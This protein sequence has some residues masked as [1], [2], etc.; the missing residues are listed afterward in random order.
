MTALPYKQNFLKIFEEYIENLLFILTL[1]IRKISK[2]RQESRCSLT[3]HLQFQVYDNIQ[4]HLKI[5][6]ITRISQFGKCLY[7]SKKKG[8]RRQLM[9]KNL[10]NITTSKPFGMI[11]FN[12]IKKCLNSPI[13]Q[14]KDQLQK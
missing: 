5:L 9:Q 1:A 4:Q 2:V 3:K 7:H 8:L 13:K 11:K 6:Y 14:H 10:R 12:H